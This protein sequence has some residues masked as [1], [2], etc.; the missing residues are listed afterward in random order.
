MTA[1]CPRAISAFLVVIALLL[2]VTASSAQAAAPAWHLQMTHS[3]SPFERL[4]DHGNYPVLY[5]V[6]V[7]NSGDEATSG[8]YVI[9]D[10]PPPQ[11][12]V[13]SITAGPG[14]SCTSTEQVL[15]GTP[16]TCTSEAVLEPGASVRAVS[17]LLSMS[18]SAPDT[19]TNEATISGG[20]AGGASAADP[21]PVIDR[22]AF[23]VE[24]F[25][26]RTTDS[27]N[28]DFTIAGGHPFQA[29]SEFHFAKIPAGEG[30]AVEEFDNVSDELPPGLLGNPA[31]VPRC[32]SSG[33]ANFIPSC[34]AD[35]VVGFIELTA[36]FGTSQHPLYNVVPERGSPAQFAFKVAQAVVSLFPKLRPRTGSYGVTIESHNADFLFTSGVRVVFYGVPAVQNGSGASEVPFLSNPVNCAETHAFS[37]I[38]VDS[39]VHPG[40]KLAGE[41]PDL[42]DPNWKTA[43]APMPP[44]TECG[45]LTLTSQFH[46]G[47]SAAPVQEGGGV[48]ADHPSGL[49]VGLD[50]PQTNDPTDPHTTFDTSSP[51]A[52]ELKDATVTLPAGMSISPSGANGLRG[53]SDTAEDPAGDQVHYDNTAP[54]GCPEE[55]KIGSVTATT[56]LLAAHDSITDAVTGAEPIHGDVFVVKPHPGDLSPGGGQDGTFRILIQLESAQNGINVKLPGTVKADKIT[57]QLTATFSEN[58]QLPV[59]H[60]AIALKSGPRAPLASPN[61]CGTFTT[62][63]D[64]VP[65]STPGTPDA[66]PSSSFDVTSGPNGSPCVSSPGSRPFGP[67]LA[68][69]NTSTGAGQSSPFTLELGRDDGEQEL[70]WLDLLMPKG[71]TAKLA[72]IPY[73]SEVAVAATA[74]RSGAAEQVSPSC[75]AAS[76]IGTVTVGAGPGTNPFYVSGKVYLA[77]PYKGAPTSLVF[78]TPA[79]AGPFDLGNVVLRA[80]AYIDS[81]TAQVNVKSDAVPQ[82]LDGVPLQI[83]RITVRIDREGFVINPTDCTPMTLTGTIAGGPGGE[84]SKSVSSL[85]QASNCANLKLAP[86]FSASIGTGAKARKGSVFAPRQS[87]VALHVKLSEPQAP[88]GTQV[89]L[90]K[91]KVELPKALPSRLATLQKACTSAQFEA[92]PAGCPAGSVVGQAKVITPLLPVALTG[93]AYFVS[94]GGEAFPSLTMVLQGY[95]VTID[96]VG[97]TLIRGG[98]TSTTFKTIPDVPFSSFEL[99]LPQGKYSALAGYGDL[100]KSRLSL[101]TEYV[102]QNGAELHQ[103]NVISVAGCG[104]A[105]APTRA[106]KLAAALRAC[107]KKPNAKRAACERTARKKYGTVKKKSKKK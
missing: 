15:A 98:V 45:A 93:P 78:V 16:L 27:A 68:A 47:V 33:L 50:F 31:A 39:W 1:S 82:I 17:I 79:V 11:L 81:H 63:S 6:S 100:C 88:L 26:A 52:P 90:A 54:V 99:T 83:R 67:S 36:E 57:G 8:S 22:P 84:V 7:E 18:P 59:S 42:S 69:G 48:Q 41:L 34:P 60:V 61:T 58:P 25:A 40:R 19:V 74:G 94:H 43:I 9:D 66:T 86:R 23:E 4:S 72:G 3:P 65:W 80:A 91:V 75:P 53:C 76:Q 73:C 32:P 77:G 46:P 96:L 95:G 51:Q 44:V 87:G 70:R 20:G 103:R 24:G 13:T 30:E 2:A 14:W 101:P 21:T 56:P 97:T 104:K 102:A 106:Q 37:Q 89:N 107:K 64:L 85:F 10:T 55:S 28:G 71:F 12:T 62:T 49:A 105:K 29:T 35:T 92:N 38:S 5:K